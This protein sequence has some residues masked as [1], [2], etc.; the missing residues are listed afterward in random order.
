MVGA[1]HQGHA[2][3]VRAWRIQLPG[4]CALQMDGGLVRHGA[5]QAGSQ[6]AQQRTAACRQPFGRLLPG[7]GGRV[8]AGDGEQGQ[9]CVF[10]R[11]A[12]H[13]LLQVGQQ[14]RGLH[15]V[16][17]EGC[18]GRVLPQEGGCLLQ[19]AG[20]RPVNGVLAPVVQAALFYQCDRGLQHRQAPAERGLRHFARLAAQAAL[21][22]EL[23]DLFAQV[24]ALARRVCGVGLQQ[25]SAD[26][27]VQRGTA[28]AQQRGGLGG[29]QVV[30]HG[31]IIC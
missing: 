20:S 9:Q 11:L 1:Q 12:C 30:G 22:C 2:H 18:L 4:P 23:L 31:S 10:A 16:C 15:G 28:H 14:R 7:S 6:Q 3:E 21:A 27:G 13:A 8:I 5:Q 17:S 25:A 24:A 26:I 29:V 19:R